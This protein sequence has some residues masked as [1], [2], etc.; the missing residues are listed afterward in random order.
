MLTTSASLSFVLLYCICVSIPC[1][2]QWTVSAYVGGAQTQNS[3]LQLRQPSRGTNLR[4]HNVSYRG[5][6]FESP[7]YYGVRGG[8]FFHPRWGAEVEFVHLKVFSDVNSSAD[9]RGTLNGVAVDARQPIST[10]V[11]RF[12]ISHGVN[13]LMAN[14]SFRQPLW[15][16]EAGDRD[17]LTLGFRFGA[18]STIPH[19]ES[20]IEGVADEHYQA[21]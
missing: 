17:R 10:I 20:T 16:G 21:G 5:D 6:S 11:Q 15:R 19:P 7:L 8:Y 3:E 2:A 14:I 13:L 18:G 12:N 9:I 4:F 1:A